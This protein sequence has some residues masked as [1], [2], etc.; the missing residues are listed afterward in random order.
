MLLATPCEEQ[1]QIIKRHVSTQKTGKKPA[2]NHRVRNDK[3][4]TF[5]PEIITEAECNQID[6]TSSSAFLITTDKLPYGFM[7]DSFYSKESKALLPY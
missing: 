4:V 2:V 6:T 1:K 3:V 7:K 5:R